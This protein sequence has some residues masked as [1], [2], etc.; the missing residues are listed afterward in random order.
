MDGR[1]VS[2]LNLR[3]VPLE[4][5]ISMGA[6]A[7]CTSLINHN[8]MFIGSEDT[9]SIVLGWSRKAKQ[10]GR[11]R[12]QPT[13]DAGDDAD[14]DGTDEDQEDEDE[15]D[16]YG[17]STAA[18]PLKGEVAAESNSKSG[19]YAFRIHDSLV[20]I[21]PLRDV[22]LSKPDS[23]RH[24]ED[25]EASSSTR[26]NFELV[27]VTGRN[28]SGSLS[29]LRREIQPNVIGRF[30]F[31]EARGIW[32]L[33]AKRPLIKGLETEKSE[34]TLDTES[35]LGAQFDRLMIVSK[36]TDDTPEESS[37]YV[38][39]SAGF[40]ALADTEFEPAAGAT[41]ECGTVGNG[42]RVVQILKSEVRSYDGGRSLPSLLFLLSIICGASLKY[43]LPH[44]GV[45]LGRRTSL[46]AAAETFHSMNG[47]YFTQLHVP[48]SLLY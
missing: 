25:E 42:M 45:Y 47:K 20:N 31:P 11:R 34:T 29:F 24:N 16:L 48:C 40:E 41:I 39:T 44:I 35:E 5:G 36:S 6:Q 46:R 17:E 7:S 2:G 4:S 8:S 43:I 14:V 12:S 22:T 19:D 21:A 23:S 9:D 28:T 18:I 26:R 38:L 15:D 32:T 30:E 10:A 3:R 13:I 37:V 27:G 1:S 33:C